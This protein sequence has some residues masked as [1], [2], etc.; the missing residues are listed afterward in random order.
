MIPYRKIFGEFSA[1]YTIS[2]MAS[3]DFPPN[4]TKF[5]TSSRLGLVNIRYLFSSVI[6][7]GLLVIDIVNFDKRG[8]VV[9]IPAS[10][11][12]IKKAHLT[13]WRKLKLRLKSHTFC[14][15]E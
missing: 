12:L 15:Q 6:V 7:T 3:S 2:S 5:R 10:S 8:V 14:I 9:T 13:F 11:E 4:N 1:N